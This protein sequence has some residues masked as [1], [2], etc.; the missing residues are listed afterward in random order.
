MGRSLRISAGVT[1]V[2]EKRTNTTGKQMNMR[3]TGL[4]KDTLIILVEK[5]YNEAAKTGYADVQ[6]SLGS[7]YYLGYGVTQDYQ[8]AFL[9]GIVKPKNKDMFTDVYF[10]LIY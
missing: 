8:Q 10:T 2:A 3:L 6:H 4:N 9:T 5:W 7:M 1:R